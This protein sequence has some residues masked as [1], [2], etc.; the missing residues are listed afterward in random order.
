MLDSRKVPTE[1]FKTYETAR[2][3]KIIGGNKA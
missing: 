2:S 3:G 1:E